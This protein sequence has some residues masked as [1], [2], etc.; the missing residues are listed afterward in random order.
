M[1]FNL[2][3]IEIICDCL[4]WEMPTT[5]TEVFKL[6]CEKDYRHLVRVKN[7]SQLAQTDYV[8]VFGDRHG[9]TPNLSILDLLFNLGPNATAYLK[10][11]KLSTGN[12]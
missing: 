7:K 12:A 1:D 11:T 4:Q 3:T 2:K 9:F 6:D 10:E 8:Q 5:K